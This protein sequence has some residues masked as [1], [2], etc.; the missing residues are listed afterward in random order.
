MTK[1][2]LLNIADD[3]T[4]DREGHNFSNSGDGQWVLEFSR[5]LLKQVWNEIDVTI[6]RGPLTGCG[7][8]ATAQRNGVIFA[9]NMINTTLE[10]LDDRK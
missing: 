2:E 4:A 9:T 7:F 10:N 8:D 5:R 1:D 3:V 6:P